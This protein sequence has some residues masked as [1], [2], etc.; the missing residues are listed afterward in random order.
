MTRVSTALVTIIA[1]GLPAGALAQGREI[2]ISPDGRQMRLDDGVT[3]LQERVPI[4]RVPLDPNDARETRRQLQR[5]LTEHPPNLRL[6]LQAD[7]S[8][9][10]RPDYLAP[11]PRLAEFL[12]QHPEVARDPAFFLGSGVVS[13]VDR[14]ER[15]PQERALDTLEGMLAGVAAITVFLTALFVIASLVRQAIEHRRWVRQS[16]V[17][18]DVHTKILD[19]LQSNEDLLSYIQTPA[20]Q[21]FLESGPSPRESA[22]PAVA[23]PFGRILW[24]VQAGV[25][26]AALG[27]ALWLVQ[28][29]VM[30]EVKPAFQ[31]MGIIAGG[32]GVG[33]VLSAGVSYLISAR[34]GLLGVPKG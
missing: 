9:I 16:R 28:G 30:E 27:V 22:P 20:G 18:T 13:L 15:T 4:E 34:L 21:R 26:L 23:A 5:L 1:L 17:Q 8:L 7:P 10:S 3:R 19:R 25:M 6:V 29:S 2:Y 14:S 32:L 24:S 33:A 31:A 11:Y 12:K